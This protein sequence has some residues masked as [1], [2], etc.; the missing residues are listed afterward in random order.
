MRDSGEVIIVGD[1]DYKDHTTIMNDIARIDQVTGQLDT[2]FDP[3]KG[4][5]AD[6]HVA[7]VAVQADGKVLIGGTFTSVDGIARHRVAR[8]NTDGSV[9]P[10][11]NASVGNDGDDG[12]MLL[13]FDDNEFQH[14]TVIDD[15]YYDEYG[16]MITAQNNNGSNPDLAVLFNTELDNTRD[17]DLES[18]WSGGNIA[19][20]LPD[21]LATNFGNALIIAENTDDL[22]GDGIL[23]NPDDEASGGTIK[24][25]MSHQNVLGFQASF[26]DFE[27][28]NNYSIFLT[29]D[30]LNTATINF[31]QFM[32]STSLWYDPYIT[33]GDNFVNVLPLIW[34]QDVGLNYF[35]EITFELPGSGAI[36]SLYFVTDPDLDMNNIHDE[37]IVSAIAVQDDGQILIAGD[38]DLVNGVG[39]TNIARLNSDGSLD[40]S[41]DPGSS[42][43]GPVYSVAI[44]GTG[45]ILVGGG[46]SSYR[47]LPAPGL[48]RL[49]PDGSRDF[50][51]GA[52]AGTVVR[53]IKVLPSGEIAYGGSFNTPTTGVAIL[54]PT[55]APIEGFDTG[56]GAAD[57]NSLDIQPDGKLVIGGAFTSYD[58]GSAKYAA[59]INP[60]GS[61]DT[62][63]SVG[64]GP[65]ESV[66]EVKVLPDGG[67]V[68]VGHFDN[69]SGSAR[70]GVARLNNDGTLDGAFT[71]SDLDVKF[72]TKTR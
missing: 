38:F 36:D 4:T 17:A 25:T 42:F 29:E 72:V 67:I 24:F 11:F 20:R 3:G 2:G 8:L 50:G 57:V 1:F 49:F 7:G 41:F 56:D 43:D 40:S 61:L 48:V 33:L 66:E 70:D 64:V 35:Q 53:D 47:G 46:F 44:D 45:N 13:D 68:L 65:D 31:A 22:D 51:I 52:P 26:I 30:E 19:H 69:V 9:D 16:I 39:R 6:S 71:N 23:D 12:Y 10:G 14:G 21:G 32:D 37:A 59:R 5:N 63:F 62:T 18:P 54:D 27:E 34:A 58:G 28:T 55:G 60:D 15:Q